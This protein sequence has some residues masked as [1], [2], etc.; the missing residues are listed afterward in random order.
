MGPHIDGRSPPTSR[1]RGDF[2]DDIPRIDG[3]ATPSPALRPRTR[4]ALA[5]AALGLAAVLG[6]ARRLEPD[7]RGYGTHRQLGLPPCAFLVAT[8]HLCPSCG[9][10]T[11]F[12]WVARGRPDRAW[13]A[14]PAGSL[15]APAC[16]GLIP[17]LLAAAASGRPIGARTIETPLTVMVVATVAVC[18]LAWTVRLVLGRESG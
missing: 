9:M 5:A 6:V 3:M 12:A 10:T 16:A 13:R 11:A 18:L 7:P 2:P 15:L 17:W 4:W 8:G 14:N 1:G